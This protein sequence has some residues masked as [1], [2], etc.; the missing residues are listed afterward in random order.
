MDRQPKFAVGDDLYVR[1]PSRFVA[2]ATCIVGPVQAVSRVE[3]AWA[4]TIA[5]DIGRMGRTEMAP[6]G[7]AMR[8]SEG[9]LGRRLGTPLS[10]I[11]GRPGHPGYDEFKR[12]AA[13]WGHD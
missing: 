9:D 6:E 10:Q 3:G 12:I 4:Y 8:F 1:D 7:Q 13:S 11:S 5:A 2:A